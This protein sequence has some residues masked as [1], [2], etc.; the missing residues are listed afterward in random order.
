MKESLTIK[1]NKV[2]SMQYALSN[3]DGIIIRKASDTPITY[4]HGA[5]VLFS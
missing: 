4:L 3:A 2:V 1:Q 5:G